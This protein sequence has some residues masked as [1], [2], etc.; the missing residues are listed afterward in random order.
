MN[1]SAGS[2]KTDPGYWYQAVIDLQEA[3]GYDK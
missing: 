2:D 1:L 3:L